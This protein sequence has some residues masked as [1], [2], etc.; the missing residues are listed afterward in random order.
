MY[1][2]SFGQFAR[3]GDYDLYIS[4]AGF[5]KDMQLEMYLIL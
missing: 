2:V 5:E 3:Q 4:A 1:I